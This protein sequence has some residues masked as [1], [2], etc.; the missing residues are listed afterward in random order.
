MSI[1]LLAGYLPAAAGLPATVSLAVGAAAVLGV[2]F[3][4]GRPVVREAPR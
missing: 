3:G 2:V 1:A 4:V